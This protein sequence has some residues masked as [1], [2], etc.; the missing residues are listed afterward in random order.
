MLDKTKPK[1]T[2]RQSPPG[3]PPSERMGRRRART[4]QALM[5][6]AETLFASRSVDAVNVDDI[7]S[8][9]DVAKGTFYNYFVDKDA[10]ARELNDASRLEIEAA[11][12]ALNAGIDDPA[13]RV[14]RAFCCVLRFGLARPDRARA[15]MRM[16]PR[17][18]DPDAPINSGVRR[19]VQLGIDANVF[20]VPS[21]NAATIMV[22]GVIQAGLSRALDL[23]EM[24]AAAELGRELGLLLLRGI[25]VTPAKAASVMASALAAVFDETTTKK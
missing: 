8:L 5:D 7:V 2:K 20:R 17:A 19:D 16:N 25:G 3:R 22:I 21:Q 23:G 24:A 13:M 4:Q 6:A 18:T 1:Q 14:A 12:V 15:M 9:A 10:L 11:I